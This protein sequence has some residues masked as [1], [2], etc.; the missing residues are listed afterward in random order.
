MAPDFP[1]SAGPTTQRLSD[2]PGMTGGVRNALLEQWLTNAW[3]LAE[4]WEQLPGK[5]QLELRRCQTAPELLMRLVEHHLLNEYQADRIK[6]GKTFGLILGNFRVLGRLG[7]GGMGVVFKAEHIAMRRLAAVKVVSFYGEEDP[8]LLLRFRAEIRAVA[9]LQHPNIVSAFDAG[10][11]SSADEDGPTLHYFVMEYV[12]GR[13]LDDLVGNDGQLGITQACDLIYQVATALAEAQ[14]FGLVHRDIKPANILATAEWQ[15]KLL[16]FGLARHISK[17]M[18][19]PGTVL[20]TIDYMA[21]EQASD[22]HAVDIR[23]DIYAL[24]A[25]LYWCL[26]GR[27]PFPSRPSIQEEL[28]ARLTL[29]APSLRAARPDAPAELDQVVARMMA[30][31]PNA[32]FQTPEAVMRALL[33]FLKSDSR[34][35]YPERRTARP[36]D[37]AAATGTHRVLIVDDE[38]DMRTLVAHVLEMEDIG[39]DHAGDGVEALAALAGKTYDLVLLDVDMPRMS[40]LEV[41]T[42]LRETAP[43]TLKIV[44]M[45]GRTS[46]D[47]MAKT[48]LAGADDCLSKPFSL[49]Q[50]RSRVQA[51]L[52]LKDV[53]DRSELLNRQLT[54]LAAEQERALQARDSDLFH[55]RNALVLALAKLVEHRGTEPTAHLLRLQ[56]ACRCLAEG[57]VGRRAYAGQIDDNYVRMLECCAPLHDIGKVALPESILLKPGQLTAE[58]RLIMQTHTTIGADTLADVA[59]QH[60]FAASFFEMAIAIVRHHH[61]RWDGQG[62]PDQLAGDSIPLAAR[63]VGLADTYDALRCR[64]TY[65]PALAHRTAVKLIAENAGQ[66]DPELVTVFEQ[67]ADELEQI[68]RELPH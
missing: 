55:A 3:V 56:R 12:P 41:L 38:P 66:F 5:V 60:S 52:R 43:P 21:P 11:V 42:R 19:E 65:R 46:A 51:A 24:G 37:P 57:A 31:D 39:C 2:R 6:A 32:R 68:F 18:T 67:R 49:V 16:D 63:I 22:A 44:M 4:D 61:E 8:Q 17:R 59:R 47:E 9:Q 23:A 26:S 50:L 15:A 30:L 10:T 33:P 13:D 45:S 40:G 1:A 27:S 7:A 53:Q 29:P 64:R 28:I 62:Y 34:L 36:A 14:K 48:M 20:G 58:E 54:R 35:L 25:T